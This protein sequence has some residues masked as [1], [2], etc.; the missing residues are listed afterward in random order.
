MSIILPEVPA[1]VP[2]EAVPEAAVIV[3]APNMTK[4]T[5]MPPVARSI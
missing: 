2:A 3:T 4:L 5:L 1:E